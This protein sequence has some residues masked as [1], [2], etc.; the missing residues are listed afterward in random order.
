MTYLC[1]LGYF[2][3]Y[4]SN[5]VPSRQQVDPVFAGKISVLFLHSTQEPGEPWDSQFHYFE[6]LQCG[7]SHE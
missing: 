3:K 7:S 2:I 1:L 5:Y 6:V 4:I